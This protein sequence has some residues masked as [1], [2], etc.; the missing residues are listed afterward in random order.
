MMSGSLTRD[1]ILGLKLNVPDIFHHQE[2][3]MRLHSSAMS[4]T[5]MVDVRAVAKC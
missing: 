3:G 4:C 2:K 1:Q 5:S